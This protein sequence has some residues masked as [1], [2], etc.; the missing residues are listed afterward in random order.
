MT[1]SGIILVCVTLITILLF[2]MMGLLF[3]FKKWKWKWWYTS[4]FAFFVLIYFISGRW[5]FELHDCISYQFINKNNTY[6]NS[7]ASIL[8]SKAFL[9]D[10]CPFL[11]L[12][13]SLFATNK[14]TINFA[15]IIA[16]IALW[17]SS[18]TLF[19]AISINNEPLTIQYVFLGIYPNLL[20]FMMHYLMM[21]LALI[22]MMDTKNYKWW[23]IIIAFLVIF[24]YIAYIFLIKNI[25]GV[26]WNLTGLTKNDWIITYHT[27]VINN[28]LE[29]IIYKHYGEYYNLG[30][31][32]H[33]PYPYAPI[34]LFLSSATMILIIIFLNILIHKLLRKKIFKNNYN[35][36]Q[37]IK[38]IIIIT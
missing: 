33:I 30:H 11:V 3:Y 35:C 26:N 19:L 25:T 37:K 7:S 14:W 4:I 23:W 28:G 18:S 31:F 34:F 38:K 24:L 29:I 6:N 27:K 10:M 32:F 5:G 15:K 13:L 16:P 1:F 2:C 9:L 20:F 17:T 22:L 12:T 36:Y 21:M 8:I